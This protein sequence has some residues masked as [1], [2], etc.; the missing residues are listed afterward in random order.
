MQFSLKFQ[1]KFLRRQEINSYQI[2]L[3]SAIFAEIS[4][5]ILEKTGDRQLPCQVSQC[6]FRWNFSKN[7]K[8]TRNKQLYHLGVYPAI[9]AEVLAK[10]CLVEENNWLISPSFLSVQISMKVLKPIT[11]KNRFSLQFWWSINSVCPVLGYMYTV[12]FLIVCRQK[13]NFEHFFL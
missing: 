9:F 13:T 7:S 1:R 8:K 3:P 12:F 2:R 10:V 6:N 4:A 11:S 5:K